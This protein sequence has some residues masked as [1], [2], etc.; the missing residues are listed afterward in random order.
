M[1]VYC[2]AGAEA[3]L[4]FSEGL[5]RGAGEIHRWAYDS[6]S[7]GRLL[8]QSRFVDIRVCRVDESRIP[9]FNYYE[10][11]AI[12]GQVRKPDSLFMEARKV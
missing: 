6:F 7:L 12:G 9:D 11:D 1:F 3:Q 8:A 4:S 10:L 5:F 2:L